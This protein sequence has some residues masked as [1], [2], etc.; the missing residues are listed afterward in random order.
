MLIVGL[1]LIVDPWAVAAV[2]SDM[3]PVSLVINESWGYLE[4]EEDAADDLEWPEGAG[5]SL[6]RRYGMRWQ[7][8]YAL[9]HHF[10]RV[11]KDERRWREMVRG[12]VT[13]GG[14]VDVSMA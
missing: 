2:L 8:A 5:W 3:L 11:R 12:R 1:S 10:V 4:T 13:G 9:V 6:G 14:N 7:T